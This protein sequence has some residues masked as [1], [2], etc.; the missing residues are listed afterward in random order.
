MKDGPSPAS[1]ETAEAA[2]LS[3]PRGWRLT[4]PQS[5][6]P[7]LRWLCTTLA[8][9][10]G[11][12]RQALASTLE[13]SA[14]AEEDELLTVFRGHCCSP[15]LLDPG[16]PGFRGGGGGDE[17]GDSSV[18]VT[19]SPGPPTT[20]TTTTTRPMSLNNGSGEA[21]STN[22]RKCTD[23]RRKWSFFNVNKF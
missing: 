3:C 8:M 10:D 13:V 9:A 12:A 18:E 21:V 23:C 5:G 22:G 16:I 20:T 15:P 1:A 7:L 11:S 4:G 6:D 17:D 2:A 19:S 14:E